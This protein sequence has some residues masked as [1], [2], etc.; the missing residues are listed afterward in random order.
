MTTECHDTEPCYLVVATTAGEAPA[1]ACQIE[2][3][4]VSVSMQSTHTLPQ[5][6]ALRDSLTGL[7]NHHGMVEFFHCQVAGS[8]LYHAM[9]YVHLERLEAIHASLGRAAGDQVICQAAERL[10]QFVG[11]DGGL[12]RCSDDEFALL[13]PVLGPYQGAAMVA[14]QVADALSLPYQ[15]QGRPLRVPAT[16]GISLYP[17]DATS[18]EQ[19]MQLADKAA[20]HVSWDDEPY[21]FYRQ[22]MSAN[23]SRRMDLESALWQAVSKGDLCLY[24]QPKV[25]LDSGELAGVEALLRWPRTDGDYVSPDE[26]VPLLEDIGLINTVGAYVL[27]QACRDYNHWRAQGRQ[28]VPIA[29]NLAANQLR[30]QGLPDILRH[31]LQNY[32]MPAGAIELEITES[33]AMAD[34]E[35]ALVTL[36][37]LRDCGVSLTMDDFGTG[38]S[39]LSYLQRLPISQLKIDKSF[40][41][42]I[43]ADSANTALVDAILAMCGALNLKVV[44]EGVETREQANFLLSRGCSYGQG[45]LFGKAIPASEL[46]LRLEALAD[47]ENGVACRTS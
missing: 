29:V 19:L 38:Y 45:F 46:F 40:L 37:F 20:Q 39:S 27:E 33:S 17:E 16:I 42:D 25:A 6:S 35:R 36:N 13:L 31:T 21:T 3:L 12:G 41:H 18:A 34:P 5:L 14:S 7:P 9:I 26:F 47:N 32:A 1:L 43:P 23:I 8:S 24:Y 15:I 30:H 4:G 44:A 10:G 22:E 28:P 11:K 2:Q